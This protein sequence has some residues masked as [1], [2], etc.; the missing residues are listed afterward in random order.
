[1]KNTKLIYIILLFITITSALA[2][3]AA[4]TIALIDEFDAEIG[5]FNN[6]A[7]FPAVFTWGAVILI[8]VIFIVSLIA[9]RGLSGGA[10]DS[11]SPVIIFSAALMAF[12]II[13]VLIS[14]IFN[15]GISASTESKNLFTL[16]SMAV[17]VPAA[18][19]YLFGVAM[20]VKSKN[21]KTVFAIFLMLWFFTV[22]MNIYFSDDFALNNPNRT[23]ELTAVAVYLFYFVNE[24]RY[25]AGNGKGW[26]YVFFGLASVIVGGMYCLPNVILALMSVYP[27]TLNFSFELIIS[28][29]WVYIL[30]RMCVY[31]SSLDEDDGDDDDV[32]EN[33]ANT[34]IENSSESDAPTELN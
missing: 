17:S 33:G 19:Y 34:D 23:L 8:A 16:A 22:T 28:V 26:S 7:I 1:M 27:E 14:D 10:P 2:F 4:R 24:C 32:I 31:A 6:G 18:L 12:M 3:T 13:A 9:R 20:P 25:N 15:F 29:I 30:M 21:A 5:Y 11:G